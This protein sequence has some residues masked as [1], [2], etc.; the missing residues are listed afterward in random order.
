M[1]LVR[2]TVSGIAADAEAGES[3]LDVARRVGAPV[4]APCNGRGICGRC[5]VRVVEGELAAAG[6]EEALILARA[7]GDV[8]LACRARIGSGDVSL[9]PLGALRTTG[10][11]VSP[12]VTPAAERPFRLAV[13][14][15]TT[16]VAVAL[17]DIED[18]VVAIGSSPNRQGVWGADVLSRLQEAGTSAQML[19][20]LRNAAIDSVAAAASIALHAAQAEGVAGPIVSMTVA[21]NTAN[22]ALFVGNDGESLLEPPYSLRSIPLEFKDAHAVASGFSGT[23]LRDVFPAL[24]SI[25]LVPAIGGFVGGDARAA[26]VTAFSEP[27]TGPRL[28]VDLGTNAEIL[29]QVG[30]RLYVASAAG[31]PTFEG[32]GVRS[33]GPAVDGAIVAVSMADGDVETSPAD[34]SVAWLAGSGVISAIASMRRQGIIDVTGRMQESPSWEGRFSRDERGVLVFGL[35]E[36]SGTPIVIDQFD[37]RAVQ[38]A[39]SAVRAGIERLLQTAGLEECDLAQIHIAGAFGSALHVADLLELG[40]LP[41]IPA[42]QIDSIGNAALRGAIRYATDPAVRGSWAEEIAVTLSG[43]EAFSDA[44]MSYLDLRPTHCER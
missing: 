37:I 27:P 33:G 29:L 30:S 9:A 40:V 28:L 7:P 1:P 22:M 34:P 26:A 20:T 38:T 10:S 15:G 17:I 25:S 43:D 35:A 11:S 16:T 44:F 4:P 14:L 42:F 31:G 39:K 2:F 36:V 5:A 19:S 41:S 12:S 8:R 21:A 32:G 18:R 6:A 3:L 23:P 24:E 13:D